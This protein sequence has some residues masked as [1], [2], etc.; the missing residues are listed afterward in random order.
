MKLQSSAE[1]IPEPGL[2]DSETSP[3]PSSYETDV[4]EVTFDTKYIPYY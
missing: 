2:S 4:E 1:L 3:I